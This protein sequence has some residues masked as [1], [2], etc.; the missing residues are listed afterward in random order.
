MPSADQSLPN[1]HFA[2]SAPPFVRHS[3][4][5]SSAAWSP[6]APITLFPAPAATVPPSGDNASV[7]RVAV[8]PG[9][10]W[11]WSIASLSS[12][13]RISAPSPPFWP[14]KPPTAV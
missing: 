4:T 8:A 13:Q 7:Q 5:A 6:K 3:Q 11:R 9:P 2:S 14:I 1:D 12:D 10:A